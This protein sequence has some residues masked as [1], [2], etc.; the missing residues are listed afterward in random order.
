M[1]AHA[2][3]TAS[4]SPPE[5]AH[6]QAVVRSGGYDYLL[7]LPT[8]Y[9]RDVQKRWPL[10]LFLHGAAERGTDVWDVARQ[11][12][13]KL[14]AGN[15]SLT[16]PEAAAAR[17]IGEA[18]IVVAPQCPL[19]EVWEDTALLALLDHLDRALHLDASRVYLTGLSLGGFGAWSLAMR[20]PER[21]AA[22]VAVCGGGRVRD[23]T[24]SVTNHAAALRRLGVW[25][26][27]GAGDIVVPLAESE[28]MVEALRGAGVREVRF[29]VYPDAGHDAW[30]AAFAERELY[31]WLLQHAR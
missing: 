9:A 19:H 23:V 25:A 2:P 7:A 13:P 30:T 22:L 29:T 3:P 27:H 4:A 26:F 21:F 16:E 6:L 5:A 11:G 14:L 8:K 20:H 10:L 28:R 1:I 31:P 12:V 24:A 17:A 15:P 18:F